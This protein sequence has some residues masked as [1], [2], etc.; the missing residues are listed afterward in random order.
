ME[1]SS[2]A[3]APAA[4]PLRKDPAYTLDRRLGGSQSRSGSDGE[5]K[6]SDPAGNRTLVVQPVA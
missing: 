4:L 5:E 6:I 3:H 1:A 2:Q